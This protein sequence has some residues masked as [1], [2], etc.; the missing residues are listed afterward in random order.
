MKTTQPTR[1]APA[2]KLPSTWEARPAWQRKVAERLW[3]LANDKGIPEEGQNYLAAVMAAVLDHGSQDGSLTAL[4]TILSRA[5]KALSDE[6][7][8]LAAVA[9]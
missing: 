1:K 6:R 2:R 8:A 4:T 3:P 7:R 9:P 5:C